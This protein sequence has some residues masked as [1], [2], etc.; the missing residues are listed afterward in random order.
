MAA[1]A[2]SGRIDLGSDEV[3]LEPWD[4]Y[5]AIRDLGPAVRLEPYGLYA[6]GR[7]DGVREVTRNWEAFTSA[8]GVA[9]NDLMNEAEIGTSAGSDP[10]EHTVV[11]ALLAERLRL[12]D[13]R[14]LSGMLEGRAKGPV[15]DLGARGS[16]GA[17]GGLARRYG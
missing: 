3:L 6:V 9:F 17:V 14:E 7:Y 12:S 2:P 1:E 16:F 10:P 13:V 11:R 4:P 15:D 5:R 8:E